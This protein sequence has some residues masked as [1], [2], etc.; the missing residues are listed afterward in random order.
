MKKTAEILESKLDI[1]NRLARAAEYRD[2][3]T[4][5]HV[6]RM[7]HYSYLLA[8]AAGLE[9]DHC[10]N[11][12]HAAAMHDVGKIGIPDNILLKPA[13]LTEAEFA[14]MKSHTIIGGRLLEGGNSDLLKM[15]YDIAMTHHEKWNGRGY[16]NK[17]SGDNIPIEGRIS[18]VCDVFDALTSERPYKKEWPV[19][20]AID[21]I[22]NQKGEHF[23]PYLVDLF[24]A[25]LD[26]ILAIKKRFA[27]H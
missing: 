24:I 6:L 11:I 15:A 2:N 4:G 22:V 12:F 8:K 14:H 20:D 23:D 19:Q 16:P 27:D 21:E 13:R 10:K 5:M 9:E 3:E 1:I 7:S 18:A 17:L 25:N 26:D